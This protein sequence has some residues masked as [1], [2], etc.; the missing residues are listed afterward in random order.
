MP[1]SLKGAQVSQ[2]GK[3]YWKVQPNIDFHMV[4]TPY[5]TGWVIITANF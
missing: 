1:P 3:A 4:S 5:Y 2:Y